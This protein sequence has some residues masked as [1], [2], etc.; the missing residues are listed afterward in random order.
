MKSAAENVY[1]QFELSVAKHPDRIALDSDKQQLSYRTLYQSVE[2]LAAILSEQ[3]ITQQDV[4][5]VKLERSIEF[6]TVVLALLRVGATYLPVS[7]KLNESDLSFMLQETQARFVI[8]TDVTS[9]PGMGIEVLDIVDMLAQQ[10]AKSAP[11]VTRSRE[12]CVY[13]MYTSGSTGRPKGVR[14]PDRAIQRLVVDSDYIQITPEDAIYM[15]ADISFDAATFEIWG[16]LLNG[17]RLIIDGAEFSPTRFMR[18]VAVKKATI[19]WLTSGLFHMLGANRPEVFRP[20][21]AILAGGDVLSSAVIRSVLNTCPDLTVI[22]GY[23]PTEN[24][25]FTCC[26]VMDDV[27]LPQDNVPIGYPIRGTHI[28]ILDDELEHVSDGESGILYAYGDGVALGYVGDRDKDNAFFY[29]EKISSGLI[30]RTGDKVKRLNGRIHFLGRE[31][32]LVKVRGYRVSMEFVTEKLYQLDYI[33]NA[34]VHLI[35]DHAGNNALSAKVTT[36]KPVSSKLIK[37]ELAT[38][39]SPYMVPDIIEVKEKFSL[40]K[41]GKIAKNQLIE[42]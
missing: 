31:D 6:I 2:Q 26:Y 23:G 1:T 4:V 14:V 38:M 22:N 37:Q 8:C 40:N 24:T 32:N 12:A 16:A 28:A 10:P 33:E 11:G 39:I 27:T 29:N 34:F 36:K 17:A 9:L 7:N 19:A 25:T 13:I 5:L 15:T 18:N 21:R 30:Y 35:K 3:G 20:L 41:N 42:V